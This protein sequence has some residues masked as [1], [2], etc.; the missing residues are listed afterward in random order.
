M[1]YESA[2]LVQ[3][4]PDDGTNKRP[5]R[6]ARFQFDW[7]NDRA[8]K[9]FAALVRSSSSVSSWRRSIELARAAQD[10]H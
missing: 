3:A 10:A 8:R 7:M 2:M 1:R 9:I 6:S 5:R 4:P